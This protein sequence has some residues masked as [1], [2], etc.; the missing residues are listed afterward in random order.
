[1]WITP[2]IH[3]VSSDTFQSI[4]ITFLFSPAAQS[5]CALPRRDRHNIT[6]FQICAHRIPRGFLH[7]SNHKH[8]KYNPFTLRLSIS[9]DPLFSL[10]SVCSL[11]EIL[12]N[13]VHG[14]N[15]NKQNT[16]RE[17]AQNRSTY[18]ECKDIVMSLE[19][20]STP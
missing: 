10:Q 19:I 7:F 4:I 11:H 12:Q 3:R 20:G 14:T 2:P 18:T 17:R 13:L 1:M 8:Y 9:D 6:A 15:R 16:E 5:L